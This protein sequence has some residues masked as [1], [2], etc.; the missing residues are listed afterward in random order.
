MTRP[1]ALAAVALAALAS[2]VAST[3]VAPADG[4]AATTPAAAAATVVAPA[5]P[6]SLPPPAHPGR[7][8][9]LGPVPPVC[10]ARHRGRAGGAGARRQGV[11]VCDG[12][13]KKGEAGP[14]V[15]ARGPRRSNLCF[16]PTPPHPTPPHTRCWSWRTMWPPSRPPPPAARPP[17][18]TP[19]ALSALSTG[20][21][22][23]S[24]PP[25]R[26]PPSKAAMWAPGWRPQTPSSPTPPSCSRCGSGG[27]H[28]V[29]GDIAF[30]AA[31]GL[32]STL[33]TPLATISCTG[34]VEP[35][36]ADLLGFSNDAGV[37][38]QFGTGLAAP[39]V[40]GCGLGGRFVVCFVVVSP[41]AHNTHAHPSP[42]SHPHRPSPSAC[43]TTPTSGPPAPT[44]GR[45][46]G[47]RGARSL[48]STA[49]LFWGPPPLRRARL[50]TCTTRT[51]RWSGEWGCACRVEGE[52]GW[53]DRPAPTLRSLSLSQAALPAA[54][55]AHDWSHPT[56]QHDGH[57]A[58]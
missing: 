15:P 26:P 9:R 28:V 38:P 45:F 12:V 56:L 20:G 6:L 2:S 18:S 3:S 13:E 14:P 43:A 17:P 39:M 41:A 1:R 16:D 52:R 58:R 40:R 5:P 8:P 42:P 7:P 30:L 48:P 10:H 35:L 33:A 19:T 36:H 55:G 47:G 49:S 44:F 22:T 21:A 29:V 51:G 53:E 27:P 46:I 11:C 25:P 34:I 23:T 37:V 57:V 31:H 54:Q 50:C 32:A 4:G 24:L